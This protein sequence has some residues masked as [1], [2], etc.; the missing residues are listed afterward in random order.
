MSKRRKARD[1]PLFDLPLHGEEELAHD[2]A[3]DVQRAEEAERTSTKPETSGGPTE[4]GT[5]AP[6]PASVSAR[7]ESAPKP[8]PAPQPEPAPSL[9]SSEELEPAPLEPLPLAP[10]SDSARARRPADEEGET[11]AEGAWP[12]GEAQIQ[13]RLLGGCL[14]LA[15]NLIV[16]G[17]V[18]LAVQLPLGVAVGW[19]DWPAFG[20]FGLVFTFLYWTVPL[21]FWGQTPGMA[22]VGHVARS[23]TDEPL[24][25]GQTVLRWLGA[26]LTVGLLGLPLLLVLSGDRSLSDRISESKTLE[27]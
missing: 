25:F 16:L 10:P 15:L 7:A 9:F 6:Q 1:L 13:D 12:A 8:E 24:T 2:G 19:G 27:V 5:V 21:A 18:V 11:G 3:H 4:L 17:L 14:D 26:G 23:V 20:V 22:W